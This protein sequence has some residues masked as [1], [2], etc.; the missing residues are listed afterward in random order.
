MGDG[1]PS[2]TSTS[3]GSSS[4]MSRWTKISRLLSDTNWEVLRLTDPILELFM[5]AQNKL[6]GAQYVTGSL[7][8]PTTGE[9]RGGALSGDK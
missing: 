2:P 4:C 7:T 6:D 3:R 1:A 5:L 8:I 9:L